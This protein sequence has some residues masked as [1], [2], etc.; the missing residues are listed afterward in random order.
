MGGWPKEMVNQST[1][2]RDGWLLR[3]LIGEFYEYS[4]KNSFGM[5]SFGHSLECSKLSCVN[6]SGQSSLPPCG[7]LFF[8][9]IQKVA[10]VPSWFHTKVPSPSTSMAP[11][12]DLS[13]TV[14]GK[15]SGTQAER[16]DAWIIVQWS[17]EGVDGPL[18][19]SSSSLVTSYKINMEPG[20]HMWEESTCDPFIP[21]TYGR[22]CGKCLNKN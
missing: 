7:C 8:H 10:G 4:Q 9:G 1:K 17:K 13:L 3:W 19:G 20:C 6:H 15:V 11:S 2:N 14:A 12:Q 22:Q 16:T 21:L 18:H 5:D